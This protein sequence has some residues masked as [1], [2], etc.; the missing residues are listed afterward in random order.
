MTATSK[1]K[2]ELIHFMDAIAPHRE[3]WIRRSMSYY[4]DL[5]EL[6]SHNIPPDSS[7][8]EIG[9]GT[10]FLLNALGPGRGVG[11]DISCGMLRIAREKYPHL[12]FHQMDAEALTLSE[13]FDAVILSDVVG[14]FEDIQQAFR[15]MKKLCTPATR[16]I[17]TYHSFLWSPI[18]RLA[19]ALG[20]KMPQKRLNWLN[21]HDVRN[22][23][24]LEGFEIVKIGRRFLFPFRIPLI[25]KFLNT[26]AS[27][28]PLFHRLG[29]T[30]YT[31]ARLLPSSIPERRD[32]SVSVIVP[33][34]NEKGN[35]EHLMTRLPRMGTHTEAIFVEGH[36]TD[37]TLDEIQRV[38]R[39]HAKQWDVKW[40]VQDGKGKGDA[41]RKGFAE[42]KGEI[43]MILDADLSVAP[44]DLPK[45]YEA[46]ASGRGEFIN[47]SRLVY[48]LE[49]EAMRT[50]NMIGNKFFSVM[51]TWLLGQRLK[52][53]L[54]GTKVITRRDYERLKKNRRYFGDFD[55]FGDF[56]LIFGSAKLN[57]AIVEIP[58][59]YHAREYG[60]T[61]ISR[62]SHGW[63]L[64][65]M[66]LFAMNKIK[67]V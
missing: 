63:L 47:G 55:P 44:E 34:R 42:S 64:L 1:K 9:C 6:L 30:G 46:I 11:I 13:K 35:I 57:L 5:T 53:T 23:L 51:F 54:C 61:N 3:R 16:V 38:C 65:K 39:D 50:L 58:I 20:L 15:E 26:Y 19:E 43:L 22:L 18:L 59:R 7:V 4:N 52:D 32:Y 36:S 31:I 66:V 21:D 28:L 41:V 37:G 48:P 12:D 56:D 40:F 10:G 8:V 62:F 60:E 49:R 33:A 29:I 17:V 14:Y 67:F 2:E 27:Q 45:F 25:R 24:H